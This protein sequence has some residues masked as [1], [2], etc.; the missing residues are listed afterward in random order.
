MSAGEKILDEAEQLAENDD[1]RFRVQIAR[2][3]VWYV[4]IA[5]DRVT[6]DA[7]TELAKRFLAIARKAGSSNISEGKSLAEWAKKLGVE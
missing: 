1:V 7:K 5:T 2:L 6:G 4:Q 3:P